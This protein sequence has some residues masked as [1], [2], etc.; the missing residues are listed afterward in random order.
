MLSLK[1][2]T[3]QWEK[4]TR[5]ST[6]VVVYTGGSTCTEAEGVA[7]VGRDEDGCGGE[8]GKT[9]WRWVCLSCVLLDQKELAKQSGKRAFKEEGA[10]H[11]KKK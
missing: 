6:M 7:G 10:L 9:S 5:K 11:E 8:S 1:D 2:L 4:P 3:T